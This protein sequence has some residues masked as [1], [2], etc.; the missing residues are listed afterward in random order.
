MNIIAADVGGTSSRFGHFTVLP[1]GG[2]LQLKAT[3]WLPTAKYPSFLHLLADLQ[4]R[5]ILLHEADMF[6]VAAAGPVQQ[7]T[8]CTPPNIGWDIDLLEVMNRYPTARARLLNDF[9]AQAYACGSPIARDAKLIR[10]GQAAPGAAIAVIGAGTGL[11]KA[12]LVPDSSGRYIGSPSEGGHVDFAVEEEG[13]FHF[14]RF[15]AQKQSADYA[16]W[17]DVVSGRGL[18]Y[19]HEFLTGQRLTPEEVAA[20][21]NPRSETLAR[22]AA[23]YGRVSRNYV[24]ETLALGGL[25]ISGGIAAKQPELVRHPEFERSLLH[26]KVHARLLEQLPVYLMDNEESGLW[27]AAYYG[28]QLALTSRL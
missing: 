28:M 23:F 17:D 15:V 16:T 3:L 11:G 22:A 8:H 18:S 2:V 27:G 9:L 5:G 10:S 19:L 12:L 13:E 24:L 21:F 14:A 1:E 26:S 6:V 4:S 20:T 25:Y 7:G